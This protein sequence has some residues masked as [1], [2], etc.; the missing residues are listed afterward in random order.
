MGLDALLAI[1]NQNSGASR[2]RGQI[3]SQSPPSGEQLPYVGPST[4]PLLV[5]EIPGLTVST[6]NSAGPR[7]T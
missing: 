6:V 3:P 1:K 7:Q 5:S 4:R 2:N